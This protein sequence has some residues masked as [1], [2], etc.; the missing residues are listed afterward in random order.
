MSRK[1]KIVVAIVAVIAIAAIAFFGVKNQMG[2]NTNE[3]TT[4][5]IACNLPMTGD[6]S[7]YGESV[8]HGY[9]MALEKY[10]PELRKNGINLVLD[11][12]DNK[13]EGKNAVSIYQKQQFAGFDIYVSGITQQTFAIK[14]MVDKTEKPHYIWS[15]YPLNLSSKEKLLRTW[16]DY[17]AA[18]FIDFLNRKKD[19]SRVACIYQNASSSQ[20][21]FNKN[22]IPKIKDR[23]NVIF[24]ES[25]DLSCTNFKDIVVKL[26]NQKP[27]VVFVSG[28]KGHIIQ[29]VKEFNNTRLKD[30]SLIVFTF[31]LLDA[32]DEMSSEQLD[33]LIAFVPNYCISPSGKYDDFA[34][35][36]FAKYHK[37]PNYTVTYA[38]DGMSQLC[39]TILTRGTVSAGNLL[40]AI[41]KKS[42]SGITGSV[43]F[44]DSGTFK[45]SM[46]LGM[47]K[48]GKFIIYE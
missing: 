1:T 30:N 42:I 29:L 44:S 40:D 10:L 7:V 43:Q 12:Q 2:T 9:D 18:P 48:K 31:D 27:D 33:K 38:F 25:Y 8:K 24:N 36:Y 6:I 39:E 41:K 23:Y 35:K 19:I 16:V 15:F 20:E 22:F 21:L 46:R 34:K 28:F 4:I 13:G 47:I 11:Y 45:N 5:K 14:R 37:A 17:D 3:Q 32:M 26:K